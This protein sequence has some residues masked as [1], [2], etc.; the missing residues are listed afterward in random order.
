MKKKP[1]SHDFISTK[2]LD[3]LLLR[4]NKPKKKKKQSNFQLFSLLLL[5]LFFL[6]TFYSFVFFSQPIKPSCQFVNM[7]MLQKKERKK[8]IMHIVYAIYVIAME[9]SLNC[10]YVMKGLY[11]LRSEFK[12]RKQQTNDKINKINK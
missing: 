4:T 10:D 11:A 12:N 5:L 2:L 6:F 1:Y 9:F 8:E 7:F 3:K